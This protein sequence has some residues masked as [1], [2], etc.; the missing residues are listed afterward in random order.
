MMLEKI[1]NGMDSERD[2]L[3]TVS[4][5]DFEDATI[6]ELSHMIDSI[7]ANA[8]IDDDTTNVNEYI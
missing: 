1:L 7:A 3:K 4:E 5:H 6:Q 8:V 2:A